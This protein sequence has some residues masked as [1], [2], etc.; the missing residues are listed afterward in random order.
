LFRLRMKPKRL[1][2][3]SAVYVPSAGLLPKR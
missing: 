2:C 3:H 1:T